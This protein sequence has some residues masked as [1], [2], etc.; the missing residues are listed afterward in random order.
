MLKRRLRMS[1]KVLNK[2]KEWLQNNVNGGASFP[3]CR[4]SQALLDYIEEWENE[5]EK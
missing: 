3:L 2:V 1:E 5:D 4:D